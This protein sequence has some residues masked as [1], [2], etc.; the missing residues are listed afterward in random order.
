MDTNHISI[1]DVIERLKEFP[2]EALDWNAPTDMQRLQDFEREFNIELPHEFVTLLKETNGFSPE[3]FEVIGF[4]TPDYKYGLEETYQDEHFE[5]GNPMPAHLVPF[6]PDGFGNH[7]CFDVKSHHIVFW[8]HDVD[9][10][11][12]YPIVICK[13]LAEFIQN[14]MIEETF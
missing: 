10:T 8:E 14:E 11:Q 13:S 7:Y 2:E 6:S 12:H 4:S 3:G 5:M 9:Y 1:T